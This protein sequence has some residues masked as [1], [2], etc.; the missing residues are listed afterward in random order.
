MAVKQIILCTTN[1]KKIKEFEKIFSNYSISTLKSDDDFNSVIPENAESIIMKEQTT[2]YVKN[3]NEVINFSDIKNYDGEIV[4]AVSE[5]F[6]KKLD[7]N[8]NINTETYKNETTGILDL[9]KTFMQD[10]FGWDNYFINIDTGLS[11]YELNKKDLKVFSR[12]ENLASFI[13]KN[14]YYKNRND[15][16]FNPQNQEN[17]IELNNN[18]LS[19]IENNK[20]INNQ[21]SKDLGLVNLF[22]KAIHHGGFFKS[23]KNRRE[24][25]YWLPGLNA[26]IPLVKKKD[27]IHEITFMVHDLCHFIFPDIFISSTNKS[28]NNYKNS[29][30]KKYVKFRMASEAFTMVIADMI[31]IDHLVKSGYEYDFSKRKIYPLFKTLNLDSSNIEDIKKLMLANWEYCSTGKIYKYLKLV[32]NKEDFMVAFEAFNAKYRAFFDEDYVWTTKNF[33]NIFNERVNLFNFLHNENK[34]KNIEVNYTKDFEIKMMFD[35]FIEGLNYSG[36][37]DNY[38]NESFTRYFWGQSYIFEKFNFINETKLFKTK[39]YD[40]LNEGNIEKNFK[41][42]RN[43]YN[44]YLGVLMSKKLINKDD[45]FTYQEIYP[46]FKPVYVFYE[47]K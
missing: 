19:L 42:L 2:L 4:L 21:Y 16:N 27:E 35:K 5:L 39:F 11:L 7:Q 24:K 15:L 25:N 30:M 23:P 12:Q 47:K 43:L 36:N 29:E 44:E 20:Y 26:G 46:M 31:F 45:Y 38:L 17:T 40:I 9:T 33:E 1:F 34:P 32:K 8:N 37:T 18:V 22:K 13:V 10:S 3:S 28:G 14:L 41:K 6:V